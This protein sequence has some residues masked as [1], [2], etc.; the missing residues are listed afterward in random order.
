[1]FRYGILRVMI[2][3][4]PRVG[5]RS[6][7]VCCRQLAFVWLA[8]ILAILTFETGRHSVHHVDENEAAT[9][10]IASTAGHIPVVGAPAVVATPITW[11]V[12]W[13]VVDRTPPA[14]STRPLGLDRERAPPLSL[15]A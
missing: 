14:P 2:E 7:P 12:G 9:C 1:M 4:S 11:T 6:S 15:S 3:T 8:V 10:A 5:A 13:M